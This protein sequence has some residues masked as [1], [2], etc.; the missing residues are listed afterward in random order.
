LCTTEANAGSDVEY[1]DADFTV[2]VLGLRSRFDRLDREWSSGW[3][4]GCGCDLDDGSSD[5]DLDF[6][7]DFLLDLYGYFDLNF[8]DDFF[9]DFNRNFDL[10]LSDDFAFDLDGYFD[11]DGS[12]DF[13][14]YFDGHFY[15]DGAHDFTLDGDLNDSLAGA[16]ERCDRN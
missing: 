6:S 11:F 16:R 4:R 15:F 8:A 9:F 1:C 13:A 12:N 5:F 2:C 14:F 3:D 7:D 10:D